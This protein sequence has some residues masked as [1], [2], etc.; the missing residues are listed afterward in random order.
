M[1]VVLKVTRGIC[2]VAFGEEHTQEVDLPAGGSVVVPYTLVPLVVGRLP[3]QVVVLGRGVAAGGD[4]V[5]KMLWV[6]VSYFLS[7][8]CFLPSRFK[9]AVSTFT[10]HVL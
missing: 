6:V 2:S 9:F 8:S 4:N 10:F 5:R 7:T 3:V 1:R